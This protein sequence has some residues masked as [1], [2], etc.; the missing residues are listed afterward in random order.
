V[1]HPEPRMIRYQIG[2]E[3]S[4][5]DPYGQESLLIDDDGTLTYTRRRVG[6]VWTRTAHVSADALGQIRTDLQVGGFPVVPAHSIPPGA[7]LTVLQVDAQE[8]MFDFYKGKTF[9]GYRDAIRRLD[10]YTQWLRRGQGEPP[11]GL[12]AEG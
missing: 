12:R 5:S 2:S 6:Q 7:S 11:E 8:V 4:P 9:P 10:A 3:H 1:A